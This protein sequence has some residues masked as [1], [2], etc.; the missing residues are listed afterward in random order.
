MLR[1]PIG[2]DMLDTNRPALI[3]FIWPY[4]SWA[5]KLACLALCTL[6]VYWLFLAL[7]VVRFQAIAGDL[8]HAAF[9]QKSLVRVRKRMGTLQQATLATFYLFG[10]VLFACLQFAYRVLENSTTPLG[11]IVVRNFQIHFAFAANAFFVFLLLQFIQW[12][13]ADRVNAVSLQANS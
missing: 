6:A 5:E 9:V 8:N 13:V 2:T 12:F 10:F 1:I 4:L 3:W 7:T 11:W